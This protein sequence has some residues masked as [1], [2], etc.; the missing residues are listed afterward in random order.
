M[1]APTNCPPLSEGERGLDGAERGRGG[2]G[3]RGPVHRVQRRRR[4]LAQAAR[5]HH[6]RDRHPG[7][8]GRA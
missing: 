2:D 5:H 1:K 8:H 7:A 6:P 4:H 3:G